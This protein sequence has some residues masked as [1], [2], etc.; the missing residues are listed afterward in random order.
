MSSSTGRRG[1]ATAL[2]AST[3]VGLVIGLTPAVAYAAAPASPDGLGATHVNSTTVSLAWN[4][5]PDATTYRVEVDTDPTFGT[6]DYSTSTA[7]TH[8]VPN[9]SLRTGTNHWRVRA[10]SGSEMSDWAIASFSPSPVDT[11]VPISPADAEELEQPA[12]PPLLTWSPVQGA[13]EYI[14]EVDTDDD[15]VEASTYATKTTSL[16]V[17][18]PLG[19]G[20]WYWRVKASRG[21]GLVSDPSPARSIV[22]VPIDVPVLVDPAND[23][24]TEVEDVVLDWMPVAGAKSYE[25]EVA[26]N[27]TFTSGLKTW[28]NV[29]GTSF[30][31]PQGLNN[32]QY[33]WRVRAI[34]LGGTATP[35]AESAFNFMRHWPDRPWPVF[36]LQNGFPT[37]VDGA[38]HDPFALPNR[39]VTTAAPYFQWTPVQHASHYQLDVSTDPNFSSFESCRVA[40]TT[41]T[42]GNGVYSDTNLTRSTDEDCLVAEGTQTFWR[43]RP[44]DRPFSDTGFSDGIQGIYSP[45]QRF[46]WDPVYFS[47]LSPVGGATVD[48][49]TLR[50]TPGVAA[51]KYK[52]EIFKSGATSPFHTKTTYA[53]SY[54]PVDSEL[55]PAD[56][57]FTWRLSAIEA[58]GQSS[59]L[60][61][62]TF[63]VSGTMP[64]SGEGPLTALSG[65]LSDPATV[66]APSLT[67]E[68]DPAAAYYRVSIGADDGTA[69]YWIPTSD[70]SF[71]KK[72]YFPAFTETGK[73]VLRPGTYKW[74]VQAFSATDVLLDTSEVNTFRIAGFPSVSGQ[75]IALDGKALDEGA[76]CNVG[77]AVGGAFCEGVPSTP[78]LSWDP[79]PG[80]SF[81]V[82]Y[83]SQDA[84]FTN[85]TELT[86]IPDTWNTRYAF[87]FSNT[88]DALPDNE[89]GIPYYWHIRPC[90]ALGVCGPDPVGAST[91]L[92]TNAFLKTSPK[93]E[94]LAPT[95]AAPVATH[96]VTFDWTDYF[97]TN[98]TVTWRG[99]TS[100]QSAQWYHVQ[101]DDNSNF[102]SPI[103]DIKVDQSTYTAFTKLYPEGT[104]HWR[105]AAIDGAGNELNWSIPRTFVKS[106]PTITLRSPV[107][108]VT[109]AGTTPFRWDSQAFASQYVLEVYK[110]NDT[111]FSSTNRVFRTEVKTAAYAWTQP[112]PPSSQH[113]VWRAQRIDSFGNEGPW[114]QTGRF[115]VDGGN[116]ALTSPTDGSTQLPNGPVLIWEPLT[117]AAKYRVDVV[118][119]ETGQS[120]SSVTTV[121]TSYAP[122][123][124]FKTGSYRWSVTALDVNNNALAAAERTFFVD[125]GIIATA[126]ATLQAPG[127]SGVGQTLVSTPPTWSQPGVTNAYQWLRSGSAITGAVGPSYTLTTA[128]YGRTVSL[129][130]TGSKAGYTNGVSVSNEVAVTAGGAL[131]NVAVPTITGSAVPGG[132]L[133]VTSG[134]WSPAATKFRYQWLRSGVPIPSA[135]S[136]S[137]RVT[138]DDAGKDLSATVFGSSE[139][140]TEGAATAAAVSVARLKST[141][142]GALKASRIKVGTRAKLNITVTVAGLSTPTGVV[143]VLDKGKKI[144]QF[145]MAPVHKGKKTL[146]LRKLP[147]GKHRLQVVYLGNGQTFGSK[148]KRIILY[149]VK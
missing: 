31:P 144:A 78:V 33:Y 122:T 80:M 108:D 91:S 58:G 9:L 123:L 11:P 124:S 79:A 137:Y 37:E 60:V 44:M 140:F 23:S 141:A 134:S 118:S 54:T 104:L 103:D 67:W 102:A 51:E 17:P 136:S 76:G 71:D 34:D 5:V 53:T 132:S 88:R 112:L 84:K 47:G 21:S 48:V 114:S 4:R 72:I 106:S 62:N 19:A 65:R 92:A 148:S 68:P 81:Y 75:R 52:V 16:V 77:L 96:E 146:K 38:N 29:L 41:Y 13:T 30:S 73:R 45:T 64:S 139:G 89:S 24:N 26:L 28:K 46:T 3:T 143:Q 6:P 7:S 147:K 128:D 133:T 125:A 10:V 107:D 105:V 85:L 115:M 83:I 32:D 15:F 97:D 40:G 135:T 126:Q 57:P 138:T 111:T 130:V 127:G 98:R 2:C 87:T 94:L 20:T 149:V 110:N 50:W 49:P 109:V 59:A 119:L 43:V 69:F 101:V 120:Q 100:P 22:I 35:W 131:Q 74:V 90:K 86:R 14:V 63:N 12:D 116:L 145:T 93:V 18:D 39:I 36:P 117:G 142:A 70:E 113:Y 95:N 61:S 129:R 56:G 8:A 42:P 82:V 99:E 25:V 27:D 121:A 66:R 1:I 55:K